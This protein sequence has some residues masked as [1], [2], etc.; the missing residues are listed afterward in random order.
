[1]GLAVLVLTAVG[2]GEQRDFE[3][4]SAAGESTSAPPAAEQPAES[5]ARTLPKVLQEAEK[6]SQDVQDHIGD[7]KWDDATKETR[8]LEELADSMRM[9]NIPANQ[10]SAYDSAVAELA[11]RVQ[12][13]DQVGAGLAANEASRT[14]VTMMA[15]YPVEVPVAVGYMAADA[16]DVIYHTAQDRW[17]DV[18]KS[19]TDLRTNYSKVKAHVAEK[20]ADLDRKISAELDQLDA[21]VGQKNASSARDAA[22]KVRDEIRKIEHTYRGEGR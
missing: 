3:E 7:A 16:R 9:A 5:G 17:S 2:C 4:T 12:N 19:A 8:K 6:T 22:N 1:M 11:Q 14:V 15:D 18:E 10:L 13:H 20:D 21:A